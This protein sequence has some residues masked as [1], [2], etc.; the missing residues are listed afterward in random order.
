MLE[1]DERTPPLF[2]HS[3]ERFKL[4][5]FPMGT[6]VIYP[7]DPLPGIR[8]V[9]GAIRDALANPVDSEPLEALL[10]PDMR[11]TIG[12]DDISLPLPPMQSPDIRQLVIEEVVEL[13]AR[14]GVEDL[15]IIIANSLHRRMNSDEIKHTVGERV[16][17]SFFPKDL[18]NH[19]AEDRDNLTYMGT[20]DQGEDVEINKRVAE[21][22]L[23][24]YVNINLVAMDG[25]DKSVPVGFASYRSVKPHHNVET[26]LHSRSYMD[27]RP[28]RS[29]I[30]DSCA[31]MGDVIRNAGVR[32]FQI[33]AT[34]TN[35]V[36]PDPFGF[37][38]KREWEWSVKDQATYLAARKANEMSPDQVR[39][40]VFMRMKAPYK[41]SGINA[42]E[43]RAVH[44]RTLERLHRQQLV[45][46]EGQTDVMVIGLPYLGPYNVNSIMNPILVHCLGLGYMFNM[47]RN[48]PVVR[49]GG[50]M[51]MHHPVPW[52]FH[53]VHHPSYVDFFE[54]V[55]S[56]TTD[57]STIESKYEERYAT[58]PW[59]IN[60]YRKSYA[61]HGV[62]P[63]YM[64][65]WGAHALDYLG[66]VI[67]VGG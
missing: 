5:K 63:F 28:G 43:T 51:I 17:R 31:R 64:W 39:H 23:V 65:Y 27:P 1:V 38:N 9:R 2:V 67:V 7:P 57:P 3:G 60:L 32:I 47:Y 49:P 16:H 11:L 26:M 41:L 58:D 18:T 48:K 8:D 55:L 46:V 19:D 56:E 54:E 10:K 42:G 52:Q 24:V 22:D 37:M 30:H 36:F 66:D 6:R 29:A 50:V 44:E 59:Y 21:S 40:Q 15:K 35:D 13:A 12:V 61:Y 20:T 34:L 62:H 25:G 45:E 4:Q 14:A 53:Q 33:E